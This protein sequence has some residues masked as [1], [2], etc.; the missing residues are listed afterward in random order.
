[1]ATYTKLSRDDAEAIARAH[2]LGAVERVEGVLAGSVNSNYLL[3]AGRQVFVRIY[4]AQDAA[5]VA[6]EW[7]LLEHLADRGLA[8]PRRIRGPAPGEVRVQSK[9]TAVFERV[10]GHEVCQAMVD[11]PRVA[12]IGRWLA[13]AHLATRDF[14]L[15]SDGR[16]G[17]QDVRRL[18][19]EICALDRPELREATVVLQATL[20]EVRAHWPED[21]PAGVVHGDLFR[22][23]V[24]WR[25]LPPGEPPAIEC[26][27]D[28][29]SAAR[30][31]WVYDL[32][33]TLLAWC[34]GDRLDGGLIQAMLSGY[35]SVRPL[36]DPEREAL[37]LALRS[38]A[39]RFTV[40]RIVDFHLRESADQV[41]KDWRRFYQRLREVPG[42]A[43]PF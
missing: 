15:A 20:D 31:A 7:A 6:F 24:R 9:P 42:L 3:R 17:M 26:V 36:T 33:V 41:K 13:S 25:D 35:E 18:L 34:C 29:E 8:V 19:D 37:P 14:E 30:D 28:W 10:G 21:L 16:F 4:E 32:A 40:T 27:L 39:A 23:N 2:G 12:A 38:A 11:S 22:D 43:L 5:G 1:M